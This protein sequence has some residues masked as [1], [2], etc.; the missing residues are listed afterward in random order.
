[1]QQRNQVFS[2]V[3]AFLSMHNDVYGSVEGREE[4]EPMQVQLVSGT[5]FSTLGVQA[6]R[7][8]MLTDEDDRSDGGNPVA[9]VSDAWWK[10]S[11]ASDPAI[12]SK[13]LKIGSTSFSIVG[14]APPKFFGAKVGE[15]PDI[16]IPLSMMREVPPH[17]GSYTDNFADWLEIFGR[18]KPGVS[19]AQATTNLNLL[20]QQILR[21]FAGGSPSQKDLQTL[22]QAHVQLTSMA[23]GLSNLRAQFSSPLK[24]LMAI[25]GLVLLI[26][27]ANIAN[28][29]LARS[30]ARA[31]ES[32]VRQAL[33][34]QRSRLVRQLLT[35][36]L[37]LAVTGGALGV[38][39]AAAA[40]PLLLRMISNGAE[41]VPL[42]I[43]VDTRMLLFTLA[44][45]LATALL[46][47]TIPA[48]RATRLELTT[49]L[50][51]GRGTTGSRTRS[52]LA[53]CWSSRRWPFPS[54]SSWAR[55]S[56]CA[57]W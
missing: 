13:R 24:I 3:A 42:D 28:L 20:F 10:R 12:L 45:T 30:T 50:K 56:S 33:G 32:A 9:V 52:A 2:E 4:T 19:V 57:A 5:Y 7:G 22:R 14:V 39:L 23:R 17:N 34:A 25:A 35:E 38:A 49:T 48:F 31:R 44:V 53:R 1:M 41:V 21:G 43:S 15:S 54:S 26:A 37:V 55:A 46:F 29:L 18:L 6:M 16:W 27:C 11:L 40:S 8:R 51:D 47:G 36:S